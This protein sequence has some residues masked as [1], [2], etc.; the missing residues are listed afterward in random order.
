MSETKNTLR[1]IANGKAVGPDE[2]P[3]Q[4]LK[5]GLSDSSPEILLAFHDI[6]GAV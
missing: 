4:L 5:I 3:A 2:L 1:S 6:T